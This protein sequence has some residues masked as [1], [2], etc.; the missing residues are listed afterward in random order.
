M[1]IV[2]SPGSAL[3]APLLAQFYLIDKK[4]PLEDHYEERKNTWLKKREASDNP[5]FQ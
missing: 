5:K 2:L 1:K 3:F 4:V